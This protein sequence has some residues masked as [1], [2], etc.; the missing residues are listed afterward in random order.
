MLTHDETQCAFKGE[1]PKE[2]NA[3]DLRSAISL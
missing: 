3:Q 2:T 1:I